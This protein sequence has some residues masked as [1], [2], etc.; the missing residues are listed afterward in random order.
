MK[1]VNEKYRHS[2]TGVT[3]A[4]TLQNVKLISSINRNKSRSPRQ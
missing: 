3:A 2:Y 1:Q 4:A